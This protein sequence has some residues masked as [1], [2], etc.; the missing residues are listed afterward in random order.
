MKWFIIKMTP[1]EA[2]V[3]AFSVVKSGWPDNVFWAVLEVDDFVVV[4]VGDLNVT[5]SVVMVSLL[6]GVDSFTFISEH[7]IKEESWI[8]NVMKL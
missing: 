7:I 6:K 8:L 3:D 1:S 2:G 4:V 5:G